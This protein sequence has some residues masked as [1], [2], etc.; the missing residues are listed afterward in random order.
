MCGVAGL[1]GRSVSLDKAKL[2]LQTM[3]HRGPDSSDHWIAPTVCFLHT[4]LSIQ[5]LSNKASQPMRDRDTGVVLTYN[6]E[7]YNPD[8]LRRRYLKDCKFESHSDTEVILKLYCRYGLAFL[9]WLSGMFSFAIWD[10]RDESLHLVRDRFGIKPLHYVAQDGIIYFGSELKPMVALGAKLSLNLAAVSD[11]LIDGLLAHGPDTFFSP[12]MTV[13][14]GTVM[15][16]YPTTSKSSR[17][18]K[19]P[20]AD[21]EIELSV[22]VEQEIWELLL[23]SIDRHLLSDVPV[24]VSLSAGLDSQ[25]I[26]HGI[27]Q[28]GLSDLHAYTYGFENPNYDE[29]APVNQ[30]DFNISYTH[31]T[32]RL[33]ADEVLSDLTQAVAVFEMP[34]GG[35]GTLS[36]WRMMRLARETG[37]T[38]LLAGEGAD[39]IFAGYRYYFD[40]H[41]ADLA[42]KGD[43]ENSTREQEAYE[44]SHDANLRTLGVN[45]RKIEG[46]KGVRAPDGSSLSGGL[47]LGVPLRDVKVRTPEFELWRQA[48][49]HLRRA[50]LRDAYAIKLPKLLQFQDRASMAWGVET[51][52]P[53]LDHALVEA[54]GRLPGDWLICDGVSKSLPKRMMQRFAGG[55]VATETKRYVSSPQREWLKA[56]IFEDCKAFV[57]D[58]AVAGYGLIDMDR[59]LADY[60]TYANA[61]DLG[62][63]F[64]VW[65][66]LNLE[67]V[68]RRFC[69]TRLEFTL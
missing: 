62:N 44:R 18:W 24:G 16:W 67:A 38:V 31:H 60:D 11:Y 41:F 53:F 35:V 55:P 9:P 28:S 14:P 1:V 22:D 19:P 20:I 69:P 5:D 13:E 49:G 32:V 3:R 43:L 36:A 12:A 57:R 54:V 8:D 27:A 15:S 40:A 17:Y 46:A 7:V 29:I 56:D 37:T 61:P 21:D 68:L 2:A 66:I 6:G 64:F 50:M 34:L 26:M 58:G 48:K 45:A 47:V 51:R 23:A 33:R 10:P 39:E 42:E 59:F 4:R 65:K 25:L 63:S 52:V 30:V